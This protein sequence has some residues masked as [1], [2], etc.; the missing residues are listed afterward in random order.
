MLLL[1]MTMCVC[2]LLR[3]WQPL[4]SAAWVGWTVGCYK[5]EK[6]CV[7]LPKSHPPPSRLQR[8][9]S[10]LDSEWSVNRFG[11]TTTRLIANYP[12]FVVVSGR[13]QCPVKYQLAIF[14]CRAGSEGILNNCCCYGS[15]GGNCFLY[16]ER[17]ATAFCNLRGRYL[18]W[19]NKTRR[20]FL[21]LEMNRVRSTEIV[22]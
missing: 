17:F 14:L 7:G 2:Q 16:T 11:T 8:G 10:T 19:P 9:F 6:E 3:L 13:P 5:L 12:I 22:A 20:E 21:S 4:R 15:G 1:T 18:M